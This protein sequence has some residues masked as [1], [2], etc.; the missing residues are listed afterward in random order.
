M[1]SLHR[2]SPLH[3]C[4]SGHSGGL[5]GG[6][7]NPILDGPLS[8]LRLEDYIENA[9]I[10]NTFVTFEQVTGW[11]G[12][13]KDIFFLLGG[14]QNDHIKSDKRGIGYPLCMPNL[15]ETECQPIGADIWLSTP[16]T[17][18]S[19]VSLS[20]ENLAGILDGV[21][22]M[23]RGGGGGVKN[24]SYLFFECTFARE[25]WGS[26]P[27]SQVNVSSVEALWGSP[28]GGISSRPVE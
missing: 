5:L 26:Q 25:I 7:F 1:R 15:V 18:A 13:D 9:L 21:H 4:V 12:V 14:I 23:Q 27:I 22:L 8:D 28:L 6:T 16:M 19:D 24:C 10:S 3:G 11:L 20:E 2:Y 17:K